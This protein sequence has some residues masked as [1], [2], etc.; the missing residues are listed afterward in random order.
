VRDLTS[1]PA[2]K[3]EYAREPDYFNKAYARLDDLAFWFFEG[4]SPQIDD[5]I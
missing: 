3:E 4:Q 1:H 2:W 5:E